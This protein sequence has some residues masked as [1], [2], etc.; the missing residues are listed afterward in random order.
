[1]GSPASG[2]PDGGAGAIVWVRR[3][4]GSWWPGQIMEPHELADYNLT[5]PRTGTPVKL[6]GRE[7]AKRAESALGMPIKKR[8]KYARREDAIL[9]ALELEKKLLRKQGNLGVTFDHPRSKSFR[10]RQR[11]VGSSSEGFGNNLK[12]GNGKSNQFAGVDA[13]ARDENHKTMTLPN[14]KDVNQLMLEDDHY[15]AIPRM[16]GLQDFGLNT[17]PAKRKFPSTAAFDGFAQQLGENHSQDPPTGASVERLSHANGVEQMVPS[18]RAKRSRL[19]YLPTES[20]DSMDDREHS[21]GQVKMSLSQFEDGDFHPHPSSLNEENS[22]SGFMEDVESDSSESSSSESETD[23]SETEPDMEKELMACSESCLHLPDAEDYA[24]GQSEAPGEHGSLSSEESDRS[25]F[26]G[27]MSH[28][29]PNEAF[30]AS[31]A[32]SKWQQKGKRNIRHL[33]KDSSTG[34][35]GL[36]YGIHHRRMG[37]TS[38]RGAY[39]VDD[40][41]LDGNFVSAKMTGL[42][43]G[44]YLH[45]SRFSTKYSRYYGMMDWEDVGHE[46]RPSFKGRWEDR[47]D[48]FNQTLL[49][50]YNFDGRT[51]SRLIDVDLK[52]QT[53]YPKERVPIVSLLSK[54]DGKAIIGHPIQIEALEDGSSETLIP[55]SDYCINGTVDREGNTTLPPAWRTARRTNFRVPRTHVSSVLALNDADE[56]VPFIEQGRG[57]PGKKLGA[58]SL[59]HKGGL[60]KSLPHITRPPTD[61]KLVKKLPRK[62]GIPSNQKTRTLSSIGVQQNFGPKLGHIGGDSEIDGLIKSDVSRPTTVACIPVKLVFSRLLEKINRPPSKPATKLVVSNRGDD[63]QP[64]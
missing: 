55:K 19:S 49:S 44:N 48:Y 50:R 11:D 29:Y 31:G 41:D 47:G 36:P 12:P 37:S 5:S 42:D 59:S 27:D 22:S 46:D 35:N 52:V 3:R 39:A 8:E 56:D 14:A 17:A 60:R 45:T 61:R 1:M 57:L 13:G 64:W 34:T 20:S 62:A 63:R 25:A 10:S 53:S 43:N 58:G 54:L 51:R 18:S 7:D 32:V 16:R 21:M 4:N 33:G 28:L 6:L 23:S 26:S 30:L 24:L 9:H 15:Q 2:A 38:G 40:Y